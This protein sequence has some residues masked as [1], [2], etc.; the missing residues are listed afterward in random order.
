MNKTLPYIVDFKQIDKNDVALV[1]GKAANLGE[2]LQAGFP[3]PPGFALTASAYFHILEIN[4]IGPQIKETFKFTNVDRPEELNQAS[5]R[6]K[7]LIK[8]ATIPE[9]LVKQT[10][11]AYEQLGGS[12]LKHAYVA[13]RSSATAEDLPGASFAGQQETFLNVRGEAN[14][15]EAIRG[16]WASLFE[17]RSIFYREQKGFDHFQVGIS[18]TIQRMIQSDI[19][20][21]MFTIDPVKN[22]KTKIVIEAIWGL[23][24]KIV[25]GTYTP[26]RY[27]V[28]KADLKIFFRQIIPQK[29]KLVLS[30]G[31]NKEL[32]V[33]RSKINKVKL[34]DQQI[35]TL[36]GLGQK[37][38]QHYFFPQDIEWAIEKDRLYIV[39]ARP[40]TTMTQPAKN[41]KKKEKKISTAGLKLVIKGQP[42]SPGLVSGYARVI[43]SAKEIG[44]IKEGEILV[45]PKTTPDFVPAMK[46]AIAIVT[47]TGGQTS[48]AA[49][50]S[51][52][53]GI[54]CIVGTE[55]GTKEL[56]SNQVYTVDAQTGEIFSGTPLCK[57]KSPKNPAQTRACRD[58]LPIKFTIPEFN[59][60]K[61]HKQTATKVYVNLAEPEL[62]HNV[63]SRNVDGV[64]LL[65][66]EFMIAQLGRHPKE[67]IKRGEGHKFAQQLES[68]MTTFCQAFG[69]RPVVYR[70]TDF[71]TN[72]YRQL[73]GGRWFEPE[74]E[75]P[76]I[77]YRG[78]FR[79]LQDEA[80]FNLELHA[81]R[82][83]RQQFKNLWL[84]IPF[85][86][87]PEELRKVKRLLAA[88]GLVRSPSFKLWMMVEIP[89]NVVCLEKFIKVGID[90]VSIGTNDLT[91][92]TLGVD[93]DNAEVASAYNE[94]DPA[95]LKLIKQTIK[96]A[97]K[98]R[99][100]SSICGQAPTTHPGLIYKLVKWGITSVSVSPDKIETAREIIYRAER[101][102]IGKN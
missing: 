97:K 75:N 18:A 3:V 50:V 11:R 6:I 35:I 70:T 77:G 17:P 96:T 42:A 94:L 37:I 58:K 27:I 47:D 82:Q 40:V 34:S 7:R 100:T 76:M 78:A 41:K 9:D 4:N 74:E 51:R 92:L 46:R 85:V 83:V 95:V 49:I 25:Q 80:V 98:H 60:L 10:I 13:V 38:Q 24:E 16:C 87:S 67:L 29:K 32:K 15:I 71:K 45:A 26:D 91:M 62:A 48:H 30:R 20:G 12:R 5:Q 44:K 66:A 79:Y 33:K 59:L 88:Y 68:G 8:R 102:L 89:A 31:Q 93:R 86:R 23:G 63:S 72:E 69:E 90:G 61:T 55:T 54:A 14:L 57:D 28:N 39:Q 22:D 64:G 99:L 56:K 19:S 81:I 73:N 52:E 43:K 53:L 1:G 84:M 65:R 2:M 36:A 101:K 21:I